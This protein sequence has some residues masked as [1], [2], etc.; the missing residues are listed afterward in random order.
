VVE[1][2]LR[3][4]GKSELCWRMDGCGFG[5]EGPA[6]DDD[7]EHGGFKVCGG[8]LLFAL[9]PEVVQTRMLDVA[10]LGRDGIKIVRCCDGLI[11]R[12]FPRVEFGNCC[13]IPLTLKMLADLQHLQYIPKKSLGFIISY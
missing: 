8:L 12:L 7:A 10:R 4:D 2:G 5:E 11:I 9:E 6:G 3:G 1:C 13:E